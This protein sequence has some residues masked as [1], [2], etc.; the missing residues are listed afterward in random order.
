MTEYKIEKKVAMPKRAAHPGRKPKYPFNDMEV[1][2]SFYIGSR[3]DA[4]RVRGALQHRMIRGKAKDKFSV[5][6]QDDGSYRCW[7]TE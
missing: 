4:I 5:R 7:R 6:K 3:Q 1:G 2:D